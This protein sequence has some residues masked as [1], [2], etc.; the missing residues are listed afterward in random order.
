MTR[1]ILI[2]DNKL[3]PENIFNEAFKSKAGKEEKPTVTHKWKQQRKFT[4]HQSYDANTW[5]IDLVNFDKFWYVFFV[6]ATSRYLIVVQGNSNFITNESVEIN[7]NQRVRTQ[8]YLEAFNEFVR[9][10]DGVYP[11]LL[12][13]DSEKVFWSNEA[14]ELYTENHIKTKIINT[15]TEGHNG[16]SILDRLCRTIKDMAYKLNYKGT[17]D[18]IIYLVATYNNTFHST[19]LKYL[20]RKITP[21]EMHE[22]I[23]LQNEFNEA[24]AEENLKTRAFTRGY[25]IKPGTE[26][27]VLRN[28]FN[29][30]EKIRSRVLDGKWYVVSYSPK[31]FY[32]IRCDTPGV[33]S[34]EI[35]GVPRSRLRP[36]YKHLNQ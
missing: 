35:S 17:P 8:E 6:E 14:K 32:T 28:I 36:I 13:G 33:D 21:Y 12:I 19:F 16:L 3:N 1:E 31:N 10:N 24:I 22:N 2:N 11:S 25:L 9:I 34:Q 20:R 5:I 23:K 30:F 4:L 7:L 15:K 27:V 18:E 29:K 26:V